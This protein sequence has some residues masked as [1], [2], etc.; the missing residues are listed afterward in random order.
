[1]GFINWIQNKREWL[2]RNEVLT[3]YFERVSEAMLT[4]VIG[5]VGYLWF[6]NREGTIFPYIENPLGWKLSIIGLFL[7]GLILCWV[8]IKTKEDDTIGGNKMEKE[9]EDFEKHIEDFKKLD[10]KMSREIEFYK[11]SKDKWSK[12]LSYQ[13]IRILKSQIGTMKAY[14]SWFKLLTFVLICVTLFNGIVTYL[15]LK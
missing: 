6:I 14:N 7:F 10:K 11:D 12:F 1:M 8:R 13:Q 9:I 2:N 4:F 5:A 15:N 3:E